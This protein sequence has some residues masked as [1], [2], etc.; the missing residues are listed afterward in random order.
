MQDR[1][2]VDFDALNRISGALRKAG[3]E[4]DQAAG[5]LGRLSLTR[6]GGAE[7]RLF[8]S[9]RALRTVG[10]TVDMFNVSAAVAGFRSGIGQVGS[11]TERLSGAVQSTASLFDELE[12][13]LSGRTQET[14]TNPFESAGG[15][16]AGSGPGGGGAEIRPGNPVEMPHWQGAD[17][18]KKG[19][20]SGNTKLWGWLPAGG[21]ASG[22][23]LGYSYDVSPTG[24]AGEA[25]LAQGKAGG[26]LFGGL[27]A[28]TGAGVVGQVAASGKVGASLYS[29]EKFTPH[30]GAEVKAEATALGGEL[31]QR[32]GSETNNIHSKAEGKVLTAEAKAGVKAGVYTTKTESG[33]EIVVAGLKAEAGAEAYLASGQVSGGISI[34]GI[35]VDGSIKGHVGTGATV[36]GEISTSNAAID[37]G[38]ALGLGAGV[39]IDIDWSNFKVGW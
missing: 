28:V 7:Q 38:A 15:G 11:Y 4:L 31:E 18:F 26:T 6:D 9:S 21:S 20:V 3:Q 32:F 37:L 39:S 30:V 33:S 13:T 34:L 12:K 10:C 35:K 19:N 8:G 17:G 5:M 36:G 23:V 14:G 29:E 22:D 25:H 24:I 2:V 16:A 1:I 27:F